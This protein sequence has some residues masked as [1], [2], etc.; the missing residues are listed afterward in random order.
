MPKLLNLILDSLSIDYSVFFNIKKA[1]KLEVSQIMKDGFV[2]D[3]FNKELD[4]LRNIRNNELNQ[5]M[6]FQRKYSDQTNVNSLKIKHNRVLGY[7]VEVRAIH[8]QSIRDIDT[9]IHRQTT[10]DIKIYDK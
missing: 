6:N 5:I 9:F 3:G 1:L 10:T 7:H 2:K 8:D 4:T